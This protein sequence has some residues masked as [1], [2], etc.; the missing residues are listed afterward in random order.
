MALKKIAKGTYKWVQE[1]QKA[2]KRADYLNSPKGLIKGTIKGLPS[3]TM[4]V[5]K[6]IGRIA[7]KPVTYGI[8]S[9]EGLKAGIEE[10]NKLQKQNM[11]EIIRQRRVKEIINNIK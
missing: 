9:K 5:A 2:K 7:L 3:A 10:M 8:P 6:S 1:T 11:P 4:K